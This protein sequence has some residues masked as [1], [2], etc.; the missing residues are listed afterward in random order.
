MLHTF[1][2]IYEFIHCAENLSETYWDFTRIFKLSL[3]SHPLHSK[4]LENYFGA[5]NQRK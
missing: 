2:Q 5:I 3:I 4:T 1:L